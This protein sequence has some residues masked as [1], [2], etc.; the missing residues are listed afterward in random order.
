M[1]MKKIPEYMEEIVKLYDS[2]TAME[3]ASR[4][5]LCHDAPCSKACPAGTD[6]A[7]FIMS[8]RFRNIKGAAETIR[9]ANPLGGVCARVCPYDKLCE[10]ACS[11]CGIDKPIAIGRLQRFAADQ[12]SLFGMKIMEAPAK[13]NGKAACIGAGPASLA[14][15]AMLAQAGVEVT[16]YEKKA[17]PGGL[18]TYGIIPS[19]LPNEVVEREVRHVAD[20]GVRFVCHTE[21]GKDISVD[22]LRKQYDAVFI[23]TGLGAAKTLDI[24]GSQLKGVIGA[25][26]FLAEAK[27][28]HAKIGKQVVVIGGGDVAMDAAATAALHGAKTTV[29]YRRTLAEA[30]ANLD[31]IAFAQ[32]LGVGFCFQFRPVAIEGERS[33]SAFRAAGTDGESHITLKADQVILAIGQSCENPELGGVSRTE[34]NLILVENGATNLPGVFAGGDITNGGKT[35]VQAVADGKLAAYSMLKF[36]GGVK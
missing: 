29:V 22:E 1:S 27:T 15:A 9:T 4:C 6:P 34:K 28:G 18:L 17:L 14:C 36:M 19:R 2:R 8:L 35:V 23:G 21:I 10:Q 16:V 11:R 32:S 7:S 12:E 13:K 20:L 24:P 5:L 25:L 26:E 30:P 33:V 3:E 31:E